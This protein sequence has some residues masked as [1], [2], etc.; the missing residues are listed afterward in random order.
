M[1][2]KYLSFNELEILKQKIIL[3]LLENGFTKDINN[4]DEEVYVKDNI[5]AEPHFDSLLIRER[6]DSI[7]AVIEF[8]KCGITLIYYSKVCL[9]IEFHYDV[10]NQLFTLEDLLNAIILNGVVR[11]VKDIANEVIKIFG[12]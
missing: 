2:S 11:V 8:N 12:A 5:T 3:K 6:I 9:R 10:F 7:S 1:T 4:W